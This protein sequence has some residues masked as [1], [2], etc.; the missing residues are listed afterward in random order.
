MIEIANLLIAIVMAVYVIIQFQK[1]GFWSA[2]VYGT[3]F[4][5]FACYLDRI[6]FLVMEGILSG[7]GKDQLQSVVLYLVGMLMSKVMAG[8]LIFVGANLLGAK[9]EQN[10]PKSEQKLTYT[11][12]LTI[13]I[14]VFFLLLLAGVRG[15]AEWLATGNDREEAIGAFSGDGEFLLKEFVLLFL[16]FVV[17]CCYDVSAFF[18]VRGE[19]QRQETRQKEAEKKKADAYL[20]TIESNYQRTRE[21]WHD[22]KNHIGLL[23]MLLQ[24]QKYN[25]MKD[26]L[27]IFNE[28]VDE[29]TLP[30]KSGNLIVDAVLADKVSQARKEGVPVSLELCDF[31]GLSLK[32][33]EICS[34][35]GNLLDNAIEACRQVEQDK[36]ITV[37]CK[38]QENCYYISV[39]NSANGK[40]QD[41]NQ[42]FVTTKEDM[43]N[44]VGH[45]LGLR[46]VERVVNRYAGELLVEGR[47]GE[48]VVVVRLPR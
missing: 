42:H 19:L 7:E 43:C 20:Y 11:E 18:H 41:Q 9:Q 35:L 6:C 32:P 26:Y 15:L 25:E 36:R 17:L 44:G 31:S 14:S 34:L 23:D 1:E 48:F 13:G 22:L 33:D 47:A 27:R 40:L 12:G 3:S 10:L 2:F 30:A 5:T 28:E 21:L 24:E 38:A 37:Q 16:F 29:I 4:F 39:K 8:S 45:G 46:S